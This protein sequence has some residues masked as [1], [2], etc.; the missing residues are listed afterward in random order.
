MT[1]LPCTVRADFTGGVH[2]GARRRPDQQALFAC[3]P[4]RHALGG[5]VAH[6]DHLVDELAVEDRRDEASAE[7]LDTVHTR[8]PSGQHGAARGSTATMCTLVPSALAQHAADAG[9]GAARADAGDEGGDVAAGLL[10][11]LERRAVLVA[12]RVG[13]IVELARHERVGRLL[14]QL[15]RL[16]RRRRSC[17]RAAGVSTISA[18]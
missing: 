9:D 2:V 13:R 14:E 7:P 16:A 5:D 1:T 4:A 15:A 10:E 11:D 6:L 3:E 8:L 12:R 18:P 17:R